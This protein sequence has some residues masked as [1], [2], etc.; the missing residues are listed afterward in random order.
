MKTAFRN[1]WPLDQRE[2]LIVYSRFPI[3]KTSSKIVRG[4]LHEG[5]SVIHEADREILEATLDTG[6]PE[7]E[8]HFRASRQSQK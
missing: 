1:I 4:D 2:S 5:A 3:L 8:P 6:E 7:P